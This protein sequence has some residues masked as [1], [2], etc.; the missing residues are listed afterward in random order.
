ME[1]S[2]SWGKGWALAFSGNRISLLQE[3]KARGMSMLV[4]V[5][6]VAR[7]RRRGCLMPLSC[8]LKNGEDGKFYVTCILAQLKIKK[9]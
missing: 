4:V 5:V 9:C 3:E 6:V 8:A 7:R 2:R 1:A